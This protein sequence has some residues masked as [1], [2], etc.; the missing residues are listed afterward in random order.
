MQIDDLGK[1]AESKR[2]ASKNRLANRICRVVRN[3]DK[4]LIL[5]VHDKF[6]Q[7]EAVTIEVFNQPAGWLHF[8]AWYTQ[9]FGSNITD[10]LLDYSQV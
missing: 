3:R 6:Y 1:I 9:L 7:V 10:S 4:E 8:M 5:Q 2:L